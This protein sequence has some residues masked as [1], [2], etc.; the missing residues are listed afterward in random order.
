MSNEE[1]LLHAP[2][3]PLGE[4]TR[5]FQTCD[6]PRGV[7]FTFR[8][9]YGYGTDPFD[10]PNIPDPIE[11][12]FIGNDAAFRGVAGS[13]PSQKFSLFLDFSLP[14]LQQNQNPVAE[15]TLNE[16][17]LKIEGERDAWLASWKEKQPKII[18]LGEA[19][20]ALLLILGLPASIYLCYRSFAFLERFVGDKHAFLEATIYIFFLTLNVFRFFFAYTRWAFLSVELY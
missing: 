20:D 13:S 12:V 1:Y 14:S 8:N 16:S 19:Y 15:P 6:V 10:S 4:F 2:L 17:N 7:K 11:S 9:A 18:H 3:S 5:L